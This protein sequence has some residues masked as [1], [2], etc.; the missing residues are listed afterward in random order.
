MSVSFGSY[1]Q[2]PA[3]RENEESA[4]ER[5]LVVLKTPGGP[6]QQYEGGKRS[7]LREATMTSYSIENFDRRLL[8]KM[9]TVIAGLGALTLT[10]RP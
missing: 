8:L 6:S 2:L 10:S 5:G 4:R 7:R 3:L 1:S 9:S